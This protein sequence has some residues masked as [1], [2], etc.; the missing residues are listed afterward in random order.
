MQLS[1]SINSTA[2]MTSK[3]T[4]ENQKAQTTQITYQ[5]K[6]NTTVC[7]SFIQT[8]NFQDLQKSDEQHFSFLKG[9][10]CQN[11]NQILANKNE[12]FSK[13]NIL[14][15]AAKDFIISFQISFLQDTSYYLLL[16]AKALITL[17][18]L[19]NHNKFNVQSPL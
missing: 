8:D 14:V 2:T 1:I 18:I 9:R 3:T 11:I 10:Y 4:R 12:L 13:I 17:S 15:G 19:Y 5:V 6:V 7:W 16:I